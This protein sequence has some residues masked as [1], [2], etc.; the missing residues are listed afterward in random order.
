MGLPKNVSI[1][2]ALGTAAMVGGI[3][4]QFTPSQADMRVL[5]PGTIGHSD[6]ARSRRQ[7]TWLAAAFVGAIYLL[8]KDETTLIVGGSAVVGF[9]IVSRY[10]TEIFPG[11]GRI[12]N[13][14]AVQDLVTADADKDAKVVAMAPYANVM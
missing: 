8:T 6:V 3:H 11:T 13:P 12:E 14:D 9:D 4:A 2:T 10:N 5:T 1:G 7:A